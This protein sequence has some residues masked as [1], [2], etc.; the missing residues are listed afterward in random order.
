MGVIREDRKVLGVISSEMRKEMIEDC[1]RSGASVEL[2][3][4]GVTKDRS[5]STRREARVGIFKEVL[6]SY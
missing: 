4:R 6:K 5:A 2:L 3:R 1:R